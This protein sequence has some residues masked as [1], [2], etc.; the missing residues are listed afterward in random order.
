MDPLNSVFPPLTPPMECHWFSIHQVSI[1]M[2]FWWFIL[3]CD[4]VSSH[5]STRV[6]DS[7]T[8]IDETWRPSNIIIMMEHH[9]KRTANLWRVHSMLSIATNLISNFSCG[10]LHFINFFT[11]IRG[12]ILV[13]WFNTQALLL[14]CLV[15]NAV[16]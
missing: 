5:L 13:E 8:T 2:S 4:D 6:I 9:L 3:S 10:S 15:M 12:W 11:S 1:S 7:T 14:F 16:V